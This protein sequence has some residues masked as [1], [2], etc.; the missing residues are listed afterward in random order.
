[1]IV[2]SGRF[3]L[4]VVVTVS[5]DILHFLVI[6]GTVYCVQKLTDRRQATS[7]KLSIC[8]ETGCV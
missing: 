6:M 7:T 8:V 2:C 5:K 1:M 4:V 3:P